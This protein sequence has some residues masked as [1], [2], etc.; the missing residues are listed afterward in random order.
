MEALAEM[1]AMTRILPALT[2]QSSSFLSLKG[3]ERS[4]FRRLS[5]MSVACSSQTAPFSEINGAKSI[6][7]FRTVEYLV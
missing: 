4:T 3:Y 7:D 6:P 5:S 1:W 2:M